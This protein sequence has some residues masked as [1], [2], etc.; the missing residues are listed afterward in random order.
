M[1]LSHKYK[2]IF[3]K[4]G[5]TA[6]TSIEVYLS[7]L[8]GDRDIVTPIVP[9]I[10]GHIPRNYKGL[11]NPISDLIV[12][13]G[14]ESHWTLF[15]FLSFIKYYNHIPARIVR[16]RIP[17]SIWDT[18]F[19]FCVERNP[20]DKTLSHYSMVKHRKDGKLTFDRY[21]HH[22]K[23]C[24]NYHRYLDADGKVLV[25]RVLRYENLNEELGEVF[26]QLGIPF[27]GTL[28]NMAKGG[29][30][31]ERSSYRNEYTPEQRKFIKDVFRVEIDLFGYEF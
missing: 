7:D 13:R 5:K 21:L 26:Q 17:S 11:F 19:K 27:K 3:I 29:Y 15:F 1:I 2:F 16:R 24:L 14:K 22:E 9:H 31:K 8:C 18:Y 6:G 23:L 25:D 10:K 20:W 4:T 28:Q 30:R 12:T